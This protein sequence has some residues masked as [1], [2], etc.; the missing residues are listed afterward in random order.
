MAQHNAQ[1]TLLHH[2][3]PELA[4]MVLEY[5]WLQTSEFAVKNNFDESCLCGN[6]GKALSVRKTYLN[7]A[8]YYAC[9]GGHI[10]IIKM[11]IEKGANHWGWGLSGACL[12]E[13]VDIV[14]LMLN[15]MDSDVPPFS[16]WYMCGK[17]CRCENIEILKLVIKYAHKR[18]LIIDWGDALEFSC[19]RGKTEFVEF[20]INDYEVLNISS[21]EQGK[22]RFA[23]HRFMQWNRGLRGACEGG[24][25]EILKL[26]IEKGA[27]CC[28]CR[29]GNDCLYLKCKN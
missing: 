6:Y 14:E 2:L 13:H 15:F 9:R 8:L 27:D 11:M 23:S 29:K 25:E 1:S 26:M 10:K 16:H 7:Y 24:H 19:R 4:N 12:G 20:I 28:G 17:V 5:C 18:E 3:I 22:I 21:E